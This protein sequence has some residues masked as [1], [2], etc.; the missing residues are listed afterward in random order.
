MKLNNDQFLQFYHSSDLSRLFSEIC[1]TFL[2]ELNFKEVSYMRIYPDDTMIILTT[3]SSWMNNWLMMFSNYDLTLFRDKIKQAINSVIDVYC[4]WE[5]VKQDALLEFDHSYAMDQGFDIYRRQ[6][7]HVELWSF[8]GKTNQPLFHDFCINNINKLNDLIDLCSTPITQ[9][10]SLFLEKKAFI[11]LNL[12]SSFNKNFLTYREVECTRLI[13]LG[14]TTK[15]IARDLNL[16]S[17][18]VEVYINNIKQKTGCS[19][20]HNLINLYKDSL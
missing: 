7:D 16:S 14:K 12:A 5:Y 1:S 15:E 9:Q 19:Y 3:A 13:I 4:V 17:R 6:K 11:P 10:G 20:K 8:I 18:T 2:K